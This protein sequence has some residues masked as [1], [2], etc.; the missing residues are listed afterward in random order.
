MGNILAADGILKRLKK[1]IPSTVEP[2]FTTVEQWRDWQLAEGRKRSCE[3]DNLN[4]K[5]RELKVL[6]RSG[7]QNIHRNCTFKNYQVTSDGQ[8][9][10]FSQ[11][12]SYA[13]NFGGFTS[14]VFS[15]NPGTGKN[16]LAAA[17]S[18]Y[19]MARG[20]TVVIVT[21]ADLMLRIRSCYDSGHSESGLLDDMAH[22]SLLILDE[23]GIQRDS[24]HEKII[25]NQIIDRRLAAIR[26]VGVLTNL[27]YGE[28]EKTLGA[29]VVDRLRTGGGVWVNFDW[30]SYR[31]NVSCQQAGGNTA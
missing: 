20:H 10:A 24:L 21:V 6:G 31:E 1:L 23:V 28:L 15:G 8:R 26:P 3:L 25:M 14:F 30:G 12:K 11:A 9:L 29:R 4:R 27:N 16:H 18:N 5:I 17:I 7:I 13:Q 2:V 19:L 22:V